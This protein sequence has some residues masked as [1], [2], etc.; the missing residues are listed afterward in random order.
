MLQ[1]HVNF[2][3]LN[4]LIDFAELFLKKCRLP[5]LNYDVERCLRKENGSYSPV[6][7]LMYCFSIIDLLGAL[8]KGQAIGGHTTNNSKNYLISF[9]NY[10]V[11]IVDL[12]WEKFYRHK[13][14]HLSIPQTAVKIFSGKIISWNLHDE[15]PNNHLKILWNKEIIEI[16]DKCGQIHIDGKF[17]INIREL[18]N[19]IIDSVNRTPDGYLEKLKSDKKLQNNFEIAINQIYEVK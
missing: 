6:P 8:I 2:K 14:T 5:S 12:M 18:K 1:G 16:G 19:D 7:G 15:D 3:D 13:I 10:P 4:G 9:M 17:V 11:D